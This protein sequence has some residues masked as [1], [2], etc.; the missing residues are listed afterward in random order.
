VG[1]SLRLSPVH[2][3]ALANEARVPAAERIPSERGHLELEISCPQLKVGEEHW[4]LQ[5]RRATLRVQDL[6]LGCRRR[7]ATRSPR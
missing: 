5:N 3:D 7:N 1:T 4:A 6:S 2:L